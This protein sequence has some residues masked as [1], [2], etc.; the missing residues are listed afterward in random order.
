VS[1]PSWQQ[2]VHNP[3]EE[4]HIVQLYRE[5]AFLV[6]A[7]SSW[8]GPALRDGGGALLL[9][10]PE[11]AD[12]LRGG[13][14]AEGLDASALER[15]G[16]LVVLDAQETLTRFMVKGAPDP[17][18][19]RPLIESHV[20]RLRAACPAPG[21]G[22]R[23]WGEMVNLLFHGGNAAGAEAL[24]LLWAEVVHEQNL[25][26]LCSYQVDNL[27]PSTHAG[28]LK[29]L[30]AGHSHL[31]P[32]EDEERF[33]LAL[34]RALVDV[35]GAK[36]AATVRALFQ[37]RQSIPVAMPPSEAVL[38]ALHELQPVI[39]Q[40]VLRATRLHLASLGGAV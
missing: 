39:G 4:R 22:L 17:A 6:K 27:D 18:R 29:G 40:R 15:E 34:S 25:R 7:V 23:A 38:V 26:L 9:S 35:F 21:A 8:I 19:F 13:L 1:P 24:E 28:P 11:N 20:A 33:D 37:T 32:E 3:Q 16:R 12:L 36:E 5:P 30:C 2:L 10:T 14:A 31:I